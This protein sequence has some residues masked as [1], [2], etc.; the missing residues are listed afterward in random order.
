MIYDQAPNNITDCP[1]EQVKLD[2]E[3]YIQSA[4][5][6]NYQK[7]PPLAPI[8]FLLISTRGRNTDIW[9]RVALFYV[10][11]NGNIY[12]IGSNYAGIK[13]PNWYK[14]GIKNPI[15][16]VQKD[17]EEYWGYLKQV[18]EESLYNTIKSKL[19]SLFPLYKHFQEK[20]PERIFPVVEIRRV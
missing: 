13:Q 2:I 17:G 6:D 15:V 7:I 16:W 12:V 18:S 11:Y 1:Y 14:N 20:R 19:Y 9:R 8:K 10:E 4:G 5:K 3:R